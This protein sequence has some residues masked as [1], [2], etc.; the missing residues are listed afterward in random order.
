[1]I[2]GRTKK[3]DSRKNFPSN[4]E[5]KEGGG[6]LMAIHMLPKNLFHTESRH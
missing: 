2:L 3:V 1:M 4:E 6:A 5:K